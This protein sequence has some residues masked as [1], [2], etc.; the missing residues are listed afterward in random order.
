MLFMQTGAH[1]HHSQEKLFLPC[2]HKGKNSTVY[3]NTVIW[4][5]P[6]DLIIKWSSCLM[7]NYDK[8]P[9]DKHNKLPGHPWDFLWNMDLQS[10][11][12]TSDM[13]LSILS[14]PSRTPAQTTGSSWT[15][16][17]GTSSASL[18][19]SASSKWWSLPSGCP[20]SPAW[21]S[22]TRSPCS[23]P[24]AWTSW[25]VRPQTSSYFCIWGSCWQLQ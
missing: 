2:W 21:P 10:D 1:V 14:P 7:T 18:P 9:L 5:V 13:M 22:R 23:K 19:P 20:V 15:L 4:L 3:C 11:Q 25:C 12:W 8:Q 17:C 16:G 24:P 6:C